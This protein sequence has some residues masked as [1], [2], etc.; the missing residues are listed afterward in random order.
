TDRWRGGTVFNWDFF[1][2]IF[3]G[4]FKE[5][6][7]V[8][9]GKTGAGKSST[10]NTILGEKKKKAF[11]VYSS[12]SSVT[13][14]CQKETCHLNDRKVTIIDTP[15]LFD[16]K[17]SDKDLKTEIEKCI[18]MSPP[19]PH[20]FLLVIRLGVRFTEEEKNTIKWIMKNFGEEV[21]KYTVVVFT[22]GDE[23]EGTI[24]SY[25][26]KSEKL[27]KLIGDCAGRYVGSRLASWW[28]Q[29]QTLVC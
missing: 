26:Q 19:G 15:G 12:P 11:N 1:Q 3:S 24:E 21:S 27:K 20:I 23:L 6:R 5:T 7:I 9:L 25:L 13:K 10:G 14:E 17:L 29:I 2:H 16:T 28:V 18:M 22:R 4:S 8:L